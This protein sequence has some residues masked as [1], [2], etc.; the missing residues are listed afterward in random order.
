MPERY[1]DLVNSAL[2]QYE[3]LERVCGDEEIVF[4]ISRDVCRVIRARYDAYLPTEAE[5]HEIFYGTAI[6]TI[7]EAA[8]NMLAAVVCGR[9]YYNGMQVGD[10]ILY[11]NHLWRLNGNASFIDTG[12]T[13]PYEG[14]EDTEEF[15]FTEGGVQA[16]DYA[17]AIDRVAE[18]FADA[19]TTLAT[20]NINAATTTATNINDAARRKRKAKEKEEELSAGDILHQCRHIKAL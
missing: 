8:E 7:A 12:L 5:N 17:A 19:G 1:D 3:R 15:P 6:Y 16:A 4:V 14:L 13:V 9:N 11:E 10:L 2:G 18:V 20:A